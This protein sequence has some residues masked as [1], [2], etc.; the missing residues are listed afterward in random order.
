M[1]EQPLERRGRT[2]DRQG[3]PLAHDRHGQVDL[4]DPAQHVRHQVAAVKRGGVA[5]VGDLVVGRAVDVVED[6]P[7]QAGLRHAAEIVEAVAARQSHLGS[8][9]ARGAIARAEGWP[10]G[11][12]PPPA[13]WPQW[14]RGG[15]AAV[16][17][18]AVK[19][20]AQA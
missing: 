1:M 7:G 11:D 10:G 15:I 17:I 16:D 13:R 6:R 8:P 3:Q 14:A 20:G 4:A 5:P 2:V 9:W 18:M 19:G 12:R